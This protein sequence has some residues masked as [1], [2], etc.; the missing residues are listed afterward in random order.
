MKIRKVTCLFCEV[1]MTKKSAKSH[2]CETKEAAE[3]RLGAPLA[4]YDPI[5]HA[6]AEEREREQELR[7][8]ANAAKEKAQ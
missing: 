8:A 1:K 4:T 6:I 2:S 5:V 3:L 7:R